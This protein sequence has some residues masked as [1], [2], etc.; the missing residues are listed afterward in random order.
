MKPHTNTQGC[1]E[2]CA[3][4]DADRARQIEALYQVAY[5][6][7]GREQFRDA[8]TL[9]RLMLYLAPEDE[10]AWLGLGIC[11]Q[12]IGQLQVAQQLYAAGAAATGG[13]PKCCFALARILREQ[14]AWSE[15]ADA[16]EAAADAAERVGNESLARAARNEMEA[17]S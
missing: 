10:R 13:S 14:E 9:L 5:E 1:V 16:F 8:A 3:S 12:K 7:I 2:S 11:H 6:R 4:S 15:A 17:L